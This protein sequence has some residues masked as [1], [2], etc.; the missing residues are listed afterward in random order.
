M[1]VQVAKR[2]NARLIEWYWD[3]TWDRSVMNSANDS[4][5]MYAKVGDEVFFVVTGV[6]GLVFIKRNSLPEGSQFLS[7][8]YLRPDKYRIR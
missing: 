3:A 1:E 5:L 2:E 6:N 7:S 8:S 4:D